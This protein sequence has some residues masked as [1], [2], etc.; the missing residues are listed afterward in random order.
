MRIAGGDSQRDDCTNGF[1]SIDRIHALMNQD[2]IQLN[3][4]VNSQVNSQALAPG[5]NFTCS[6]NIYSW[7]FGAIWNGYNESFTELQI[8]RS[9]GDRSY[10]KVGNTTIMVEENTTKLYEYPLSS[11]LPFQEGD[12]LGFYQPAASRSQLEL[13]FG[14]KYTYTYTHTKYYTINEDHATSHFNVANELV[15]TSNQQL[16]IS[17][18]T[19]KPWHMQFQLHNNKLSLTRLSRLC[20]WLHEYGEDEDPAWTGQCWRNRYTAS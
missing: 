9:N 17:I 7:I 2:R 16:L 20:V 15:E 18:K 1:M 3:I 19:G 10:T 4:S 12:I 14:N 8:W 5:M 6:G 11:P 13:M